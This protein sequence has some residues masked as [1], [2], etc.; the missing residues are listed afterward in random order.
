[1]P[2]S[3][4]RNVALAA[5][6]SLTLALVLAAV[7]LLSRQN[8]LAPIQI[9]E[10]PPVSDGIRVYVSGAVANSGAYSWTPMT[11]FPT[12]M[13]PP[14]CETSDAEPIVLNLAARVL[15]EARYHV[16]KTGEPPPALSRYEVAVMYTWI[17]RPAK[18]QTTAIQTLEE[19][20][21]VWLKS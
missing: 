14:R 7:V 6:G 8:G 5:L 4:T 11:A 3:T 19:S 16:L 9:V 17:R 10:P 1:M 12:Q 18:L 21:V 2:A 20:P 15:N 13:W